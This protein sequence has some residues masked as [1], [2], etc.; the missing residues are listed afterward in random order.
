LATGSRRTIIQP[1][2]NKEDEDGDDNTENYTALVQRFG[3]I[4]R[5]WAAYFLK[6]AMSPLN[7]LGAIKTLIATLPAPQCPNFDYLVAWGKALCMRSRANIKG[8]ILQRRWQN[9][10]PEQRVLAWM[11]CHTH[12]TNAMPVDLPVGGTMAGLDP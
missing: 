5:E 3:Y 1:N 9:P 7:A 10:H 11:Q 2:E 12:L 4:P 6:P 8:S